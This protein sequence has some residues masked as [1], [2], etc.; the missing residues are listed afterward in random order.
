MCTDKK[1]PDI[2]NSCDV[3]ESKS[4]LT[5]KVRFMLRYVYLHYLKDYDWILNA[6]DDTYVMMENLRFSLSLHSPDLPGYLD[7]HF[8]MHLK[9][10]CMS[11]GAGYVNSRSGLKKVIEVAFKENGCPPD[12]KDEDLDIG[13]CLQM[14]GVPPFVSYDKYGRETLHTDKDWQHIY[15]TV[16]RY[17]KKYSWNGLSDGGGCCSQFSVTFHRVNPVYVILQ[18]GGCCS[19]FSVTFHH[20]NPQSMLC[21]REK[22][23]GCCSQ[24]SVTFHHVNPV[25][26]IL[27]GGEWCSQFSVTFHYVNP[28][29]MLFF[30]EEICPETSEVYKLLQA[31][32]ASLPEAFSN[33]SVN[34]CATFEGE[35]DMIVSEKRNKIKNACRMKGAYSLNGLFRQIHQIVRRARA[36]RIE[37]KLLDIPNHDL[38]ETLGDI[39]SELGFAYEYQIVMLKSE[40]EVLP[41][42]DHAVS[43]T[44]NYLKQSDATLNRWHI[45]EAV[46]DVPPKKSLSRAEK[47]LTRIQK[48]NNVKGIKTQKWRLSEI[49]KQPGLRIPD[50]DGIVYK[51]FGCFTSYGTL[52]RPDKYG[53]RGQLH[54]RDEKTSDYAL[55]YND[56]VSCN[57]V[58]RTE[59]ERDNTDIHQNHQPIQLC[60]HVSLRNKMSKEN[61]E[62]KRDQTCTAN[63]QNTTQS[64]DCCPVYDT[65]C[66]DIKDI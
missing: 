45:L 54:V 5:R 16:P 66:V 19:Q 18:G 12:G 51:F 31:N 6:D 9:Q 40:A 57:S 13:K 50:S 64:S 11:G 58:H 65:T 27:Q 42:A 14:A 24:F 34:F 29:S 59:I 33:F 7:Y 1:Q 28:Q 62:C 17:L 22:G 60:S 8:N 35:A 48:T 56:Q 25:Y 41:L 46:T 52:C 53:F 21:Y 43:C 32:G 39:A 10:V 61:I 4:H 36:S 37:S 3:K 20:V 63:K 2:L 15:G 26:V 38:M 30:R 49:F 47:V 55:L 44:M 23:G